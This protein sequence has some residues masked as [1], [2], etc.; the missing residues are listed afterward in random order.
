MIQKILSWALAGLLLANL[1][2]AQ[3]FDPG[4]TPFITRPGNVEK[5]RQLPDGKL[6]VA[7]HFCM[8]NRVAEAS[9]ARFWPDGTLD[10]AFQ[11]DIPFEVTAMAVQPDGKVIIGGSYP[12]PDTE[13][14]TLI[15]LN[16]DGTQDFSFQA[17]T[18][19]QG[20]INDIE[21]EFNGT[22][23]V[24]GAFTLYDGMQAQGLVRLQSDGSLAQI[25]Q[26]SPG[27]TIFVSDL[28]TQVNG[29]FVIGGTR[30]GGPNGPEGYLS[31]RTYNG[32]P[33][34]N[35]SFSADLPGVN[36]FMTS[37]RDITLDGLGRVVLTA[38]TFLIRYAVVVLNVDGS[39]NNWSDIFGIPMALSLAP[40]GDIMVAG[41]FNGANAVHR[42]L[43]GE[44][45]AYYSL[46][47]GADGTIRQLLYLDDGSYV[48]GGNF[49]S[50]NGAP[51]LS[52]ERCSPQGVPDNSFEAMLERPGIVNAIARYD[53]GRICIGGDFAMVGDAHSVNVARLQLSD[54]SLDPS[55]S[56]PNLLYRNHINAVSIDAEG[57]IILGGTN[58]ATGNNMGQSPLLRL[59]ANGQIDPSFTV[60]PLPLGDIHHLLPLPNGQTLAGGGF[61]VFN[62][63]IVAQNIA[64]YHLD[65]SL[66]EAFSSRI[67]GQ[68]GGFLQRPDGRILIGGD[69]LS[70]DNSPPAPLLQMTESLDL[71]NAFTPPASFS[72]LGDCELAF[73][74][75]ADGRLLVA[76]Q[77]AIGNDSCLVRL[78]PNG[79]QDNTFA[80]TAPFRPL[81]GQENGAP[82][83]VGLLASGRILVAGP[84]DSIGTTP[85]PQMAVLENDGS[86]LETLDENGF[87]TQ[88]IRAA[89]VID[90]QTFLI[91]GRLEDPAS[92]DQFGLAK[93]SLDLP[94]EG[95]I[96]GRV[97]TWGGD[98]VPNATVTLSGGAAATTQT[99]QNG[100]FGFIHLEAGNSYTL[101]ASRP[102]APT[103]GVS[104]FDLIL[105]SQHILGVQMFSSP[106][107]QIAADANRSQSISL[108]D[109]IALRKAILLFTSSLT[110]GPQWIF[111][112]A[113]YDFPNPGNPWQEAYP[114]TIT[115]EAL[116]SGGA[117]GADFIG[118]KRGDVN[119]DVVI[120]N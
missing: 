4:F 16:T 51:A 104:T 117:E 1:A 30:V 23:L 20:T 6:M 86:L 65:G 40:S 103:N 78:M 92:P 18:I 68:A 28:I 96:S 73:A 80:L 91:G 37:I 42:Y 61:T 39:I 108:I 52:M 29:R 14:L 106:Y 81:D 11:A 9:V 82:T 70:L 55:F 66:D 98:P 58:N 25:I 47:A 24:G 99:D 107:V 63:G 57:R 93:A 13:A 79:Q 27:Q 88:V 8:A 112:D 110:E 59:L 101:E 3:T 38:S 83:D 95:Y 75:Q 19:P 22:L 89:L 12:D 32:Q 5:I 113:A 62:P 69:G 87:A 48:I 105:I 10:P 50:F 17:G 64:L 35:F 109:M 119:G 31:Y 72:C 49:S 116:P 118:I 111:V 85:I 34:G 84:V 54:G 56:P 115:I 76:G 77:F 114:T 74:E 33:V 97:L 45:L 67:T 102:D 60:S 100:E 36:N 53:Q 120:T 43:P 90:G 46:G 94:Y 15:R 71:D 7:G 21:V 44:G 2:G 26:L 41:S